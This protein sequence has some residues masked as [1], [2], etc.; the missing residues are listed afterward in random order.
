MG[1]AAYDLVA[2]RC[3]KVSYKCKNCQRHL[4]ALEVRD[5]GQPC[6]VTFV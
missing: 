4:D 2:E 3:P 6:N 1:I 5:V